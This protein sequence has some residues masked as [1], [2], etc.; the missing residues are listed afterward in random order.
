MQTIRELFSEHRKIDRRIEKVVDYAAED[1][2]RLAAEIEEYEA[3]DNVENNFRKFL[4]TFQAGVQSG[5]VTE[6]GIWVSGFYGSGKSSFTKYLGFALDPN[7]KVH[8]RPFLE[9][10]RDRLRTVE[11]QA[12]LT[13]A[14]K[15]HPTAVV[16]LDLATEQHDNTATPVSNIL[17]WKVL[18]QA[19]YSKEKK[20]AQLELTLQEKD[21][22]EQFCQAYEKKFSGAWEKIHHD[23]LLGVSRAS[24]LLPGILPQDFPEPS[25]FQSLRFEMALDARD[26]ARRMIEVVYKQHPGAKNILFLV[27]EAGQYVAPRGEL[28]LNMDG[29]ARNL[30][31]LGN[32]HVW[33]V[34]TGQQTLAEIVEKAAYNTTELNKL[35]DR[36]P[37]TIELDARD[38][39]EITYRRLLTKSNAGEAR[40]RSLFAEKGQAMVLHTR[41]TGTSLYK[42][43][44]TADDFVRL[45]PFLPQH[46]EVLLELIRVMARS[47]GGVGLRSAIRVIQDVLVDTSRILPA[48]EMR[49]A[50]RPIGALSTVTDFYKT[51]R[52][53]INK[54]MP[55]VVIGVDKVERAFANEP[56]Y[57]RV[58]Q[59]VAALQLLE[60]FPRTAENIAALLYTELGAPGLLDDVRQAL[61][62]LSNTKEIRLSEDP[63]TG[64]YLFLSESVAPLLNKRNTYAPTGGDV[65][66][67]RNEL[68]K[69]ALTPQPSTRLDNVKDVRATVKAEK[70]SLT[71]DQEDIV[72]Q[73]SM[74]SPERWDAQRTLL[75]SETAQAAEYRNTILWLFRASSPVEDLLPDV[76]RSEYIIRPGVV[77]ERSADK[78]VLQF[79]RAERKTAET[80]RERAAAALRDMLMDGTFIFRGRPIPVRQQGETLEDVAR[81][82]LNTVAREVL[83]QHHLVKIRPSTNQAEQFLNVDRLD[84]MTRERDP[85]QFVTQQGGAPRVDVNHPALAETLRAFKEKAEQNG[86]R[87]DG[88]FIQDLFAADPY[89]WSKDAARYLF[90]ALLV[91]GEVEFHADQQTI[92]TASPAAAE[93]VKSTLAFN[94][95]GVGVRGSRPNLEVLNRAALRIQD[96]F[97]DSTVLPLED[98]ISQAARKHLPRFIELH[99]ALP[100]RLRLLNLAGEERARGLLTRL[101]ELIR[102]DA[103]EAA[104]RLGGQETTLVEDIRWAREATRALDNGG[105]VDLEQAR[106]LMANLAELE[107]YDP[108]LRARL[109]LDERLQMLTLVNQSERFYEILPDVRTTLQNARERLTGLF[110]HLE[111]AYQSALQEAQLDLEALPE[112]KR[113]EDV[114]RAEIAGRLI[115]QPATLNSLIEVLNA[116]KAL[117]FLHNGLASRLNGWREEVKRLGVEVV[118]DEPETESVPEIET[119]SFASLRPSALIAREADLDTWLNSLKQRLLERLKAGKKI[120]LD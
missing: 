62:V 67:V 70:Q 57:I 50:D 31:E 54:S 3:T 28:I 19:G 59:T 15:N 8:A 77:D 53:D 4:E 49:L 82:M 9:L 101:T 75:L 14:A 78:D 46:F 35:R 32:G 97:G 109:E 68:L 64:G 61:T 118:I 91:A 5:Q 69:A 95:V 79:L 21:L 6:V 43:D 86:G 98:K 33:I 81:A 25:S 74:V 10:L 94:R 115:Y 12:L 66:R 110:H 37:I 13:T 22:Y 58:V 47:T 96:L 92:R 30:K 89:G 117:L 63:Q 87:L 36:F 41:L 72:I 111:Y 76:V 39:R 1:E 24:Q 80:N 17:Y 112:W 73:L 107:Q 42:N 23:P 113:V 83:H 104:T 71:G 108:G 26:L 85:L 106:R 120:R 99:G 7:R 93:L 102:G 55:H 29:L 38:I 27:D 90:A 84:R 52:A 88:K 105:E 18:R 51:L 119:V 11:L 103:S 40:L 114:D 2:D 44:P 45:Y 65:T 56:L 60:G 100:D 34:A 20:L 48:G 16:M 116:Y